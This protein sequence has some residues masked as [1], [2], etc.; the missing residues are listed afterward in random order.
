MATSITG[1]PKVPQ[2]FFAGE[3]QQRKEEETTVRS[4]VLE[5]ALRKNR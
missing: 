3:E 1:S 5:N 4:R 2:R